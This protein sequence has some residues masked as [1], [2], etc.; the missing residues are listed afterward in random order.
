[1]YY[2]LYLNRKRS[3]VG[4]L[5]LNRIS[6]LSFRFFWVRSSVISPNANGLGCYLFKASEVPIV[7]DFGGGISIDGLSRS[8][9]GTSYDSSAFC[10]AHCCLFLTKDPLISI[11]FLCLSFRDD[12]VLLSLDCSSEVSVLFKFR[13]LLLMLLLALSFGDLIVYSSLMNTIW[14]ICLVVSVFTTGWYFL[15]ISISAAFGSRRSSAWN[16]LKA[17]VCNLDSTSTIPFRMSVK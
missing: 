14:Q 5:A 8:N 1:M 4:L 13:H 10:S 15:L 7:G 11:D 2:G 6:S 17:L 9:L 16:S 12:C 3:E